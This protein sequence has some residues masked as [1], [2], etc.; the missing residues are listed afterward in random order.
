MDIRKVIKNKG[1]T[2]KDVADKMPNSRE[3][4]IGIT[5]GAFSQMLNGHVSIET[6]RS[7]ASIVGCKVGDFFA[8]EV[9]PKED[10]TALVQ[11][12]DNLYSAKS[13]HDLL[14]LAKKIADKTKSE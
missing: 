10:F 5:K 4:K 7:I 6:L 8:D 3:N 12:G 13:P 11:D 14:E 9:T 2:L 1:L